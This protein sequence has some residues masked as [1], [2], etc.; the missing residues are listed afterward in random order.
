LI[1]D[2]DEASMRKMERTHLCGCG[3]N[4]VMSYGGAF[5]YPGQHILRCLKDPSHVEMR[6]RRLNT[7]F[8]AAPGGGHVEVDI[9][10]QQPVGEPLARPQTTQEMTQRF[11]QAEAIGMWPQK[12][13]QAQTLILVR[14]ALAYGLD[15][16]MGEIQPFQGKPYITIRGRRRKDEEAGHHPDITFRPLTVLERTTYEEAQVVAPHDLCQVCMLTTEWG[17]RVEGFGKVTLLERTQRTEKNVL[18]NP[19]VAANPIEMVQKRAERRAREMAYGPIALPKGLPLEYRPLEEGDVVEGESRDVPAAA[20]VNLPADE[21]G[22]LLWPIIWPQAQDMGLNLHD[23]RMALAPRC[24]TAGYGA[25]LEYLRMGGD[26]SPDTSPDTIV[27]TIVERLRAYAKMTLAKPPQEPK[28][29]APQPSS[30]P[31]F[32]DG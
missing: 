9:M 27:D 14:V 28:A 16:W 7:R 13:T 11:Q 5:G 2:L 25:L 6:R 4:L 21:M 8:L 30:E 1:I 12:M 20:P 15:P 22:K 26:A 24:S 32:P 3:G 17:N 31:L 10:T 18:R 19:V 29:A 23:V